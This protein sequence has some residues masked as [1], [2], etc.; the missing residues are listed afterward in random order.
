[1]ISK[2][3]WNCC[4]LWK[5]D[6][7]IKIHNLL[8]KPFDLW[9]RKKS[10]RIL[11]QSITMRQKGFCLTI[12]VSSLGFHGCKKI[13]KRLS[14][15]CYIF[16]CCLEIGGWKVTKPFVNILLLFFLNNFLC[17]H[18]SNIHMCMQKNTNKQATYFAVVKNI[19]VVCSTTERN[20]ATVNPSECVPGI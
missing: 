1:M 6:L 16:S 8:G 20:G 5:L 18:S 12:T 9:G 15:Y 3:C 4:Y 17:L 10:R 19:L 11:W 2:R 13:E 14:K 7:W